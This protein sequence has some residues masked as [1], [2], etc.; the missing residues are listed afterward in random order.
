MDEWIG[1][2]NRTCGRLIACLNEDQFKGHIVSNQGKWEMHIGYTRDGEIS[3]DGRGNGEIRSGDYAIPFTL[4]TGIAFRSRNLMFT[5]CGS[6]P[7]CPS[8]ECIEPLDALRF[9][10]LLRNDLN[11]TGVSVKP[12]GCVQYDMSMIDV[13]IT[14]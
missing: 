14:F 12:N 1:A 10:I 8:A 13:S 9:L 3:A 4:P 7:L 11:Q 6:E 5:V 2:F